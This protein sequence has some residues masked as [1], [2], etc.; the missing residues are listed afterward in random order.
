MTI[1][2]INRHSPFYI[3]NIS[4]GKNITTNRNE[5]LLTCFNGPNQQPGSEHLRFNA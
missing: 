2:S 5:V 4:R 3:K 1:K